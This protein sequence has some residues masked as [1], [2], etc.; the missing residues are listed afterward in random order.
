[1]IDVGQCVRIALAY[2]NK[3]R[4]LEWLAERL[5]TNTGMAAYH[6]RTAKQNQT[7]IEKLAKA[8]NMSV[9]EFIALGEVREKD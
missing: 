2:E 1:M 8:F 5:G 7:S 3:P 9:A 4:E 6:R